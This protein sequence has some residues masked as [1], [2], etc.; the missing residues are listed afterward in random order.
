MTSYL[1]SGK[2]SVFGAKYLSRLREL[3]LNIDWYLT[4]EGEMLFLYQQ[5]NVSIDDVIVRLDRLERHLH[6]ISIQLDM[7]LSSKKG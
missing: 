4:G 6:T 5:K 7:L 2:R 1:G 3:G